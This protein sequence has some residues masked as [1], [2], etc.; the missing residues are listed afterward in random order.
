M[1][2]PAADPPEFGSD[3]EDYRLGYNDGF[4][5]GW[6][7]ARNAVSIEVDELLDPYGEP[8]EDALYR[9]RVDNG[10]EPRDA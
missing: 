9:A 4:R 5:E 7:A 1:N 10:W 2:K 6:E 3:S 8:L